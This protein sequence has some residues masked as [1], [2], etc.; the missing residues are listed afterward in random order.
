MK[1]IF[2]ASILAAALLSGCAAIDDATR[3][4][5]GTRVSTSQI[6]QF[7]VGASN[8]DEI[9]AALGA[10]QGVNQVGDDSHLVYQYSEVNSFASNTSEQ[11]TFVIGKNGVLKQVLTGAGKP[12][13]PFTGRVL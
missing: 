9:M 12:T 5:N 11:T 1:T 3:H 13:N 7:K 2:T 10:P 4:Q 8:K 6:Q